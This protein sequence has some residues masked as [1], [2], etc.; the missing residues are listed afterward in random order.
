MKKLNLGNITAGLETLKELAE[1]NAGIA[2][3][4]LIEVSRIDL[5]E[6]NIYAS[7]D[8]DESIRELADQIE[9]VGLLNPLCVIRHD[10]RYTIFSGERRFKAISL[11]GWAKVA[12]RV[13]EGVS[14]ARTQLMLHIANGQREYAPEL[15]LAI[16]EEYRAL[17]EELKAKGELKGGI[18]NGIAKLMGATPRQ[19]N[20][21]YNLSKHLTEDEKEEIQAGNLNYS[22]AQAIVSRRKN[23]IPADTTEI[24]VHR[25]PESPVEYPPAEKIGNTSDFEIPAPTKQKETAV[26][27]QERESLLEAVILSGQ[28]WNTEDLRDYYV[29]MMPTTK[30]AIK[31]ILKPQYGVAGGTLD[32][33]DLD[34][35]WTCTSSKLL[36]ESDNHRK[37]VSYPYSDVD[38][39][40][41]ELYRANRLAA[42]ER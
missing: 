42:K 40:V 10:D 26:D 31:G 12:C 25:E 35:F 18:Q 21:Y 19:M 23:E 34:G 16:Y 2:R 7:N 29:E 6:K 14:P 20:N 27:P 36:L 4:E 32:I 3:D 22:D 5:A 11:L 13:F 33:P 38:A 30:E 8:T 28:I 41:R 39:A 17:L 1:Q 9:E 24:T 15:R 37:T